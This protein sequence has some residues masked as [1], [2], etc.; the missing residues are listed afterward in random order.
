LGLQFVYYQ[1]HFLFGLLM[2]T[3]GVLMGKE[4]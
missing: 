2:G 4:S 3:L 1:Y